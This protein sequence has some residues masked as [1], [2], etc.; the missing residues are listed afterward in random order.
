ML[1]EMA[2]GTEDHIIGRSRGLTSSRSV[3]LS[4]GAGSPSTSLVRFAKETPSSSGG[5]RSGTPRRRQTG[6]REEAAAV[7]GLADGRQPSLEV[8]QQ[9]VPRGFAG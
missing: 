9:Q 8:R 1:P 6:Y 3:R 2:Y 7:A 5:S 4:S